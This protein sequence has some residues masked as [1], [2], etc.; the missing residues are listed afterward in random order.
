[1]RE[2][3]VEKSVCRWA[4]LNDIWAWKLT[5]IGWMGIPDRLFIFPDMTLVF[6]E[7]KAP[8][9]EARPLQLAMHRKLRQRGFTVYVEDNKE[10]AIQVLTTHL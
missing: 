6:I 10:H 3:S 2:R 9:K 7:F 4:K 5:V 8:G 1:M